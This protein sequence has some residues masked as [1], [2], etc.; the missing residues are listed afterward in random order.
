MIDRERDLMIGALAIALVLLAIVMSSQINRLTKHVTRLERAQAG[1]CVNGVAVL[2]PDGQ[3][4][5]VCAP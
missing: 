1:W 3:A 5:S 4:V 2:T